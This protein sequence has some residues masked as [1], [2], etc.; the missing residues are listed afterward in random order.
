MAV[1]PGGAVGCNALDAGLALGTTSARNK[2]V[3]LNSY[4]INKYQDLIDANSVVEWF[5]IQVNG[6][7]E[8][9]FTG[10]K[11]G[12]AVTYVHSTK[13][14]AWMLNP[15]IYRTTPIIISQLA[16]QN[17]ERLT[18]LNELKRELSQLKM[19]YE[20]VKHDAVRYQKLIEEQKSVRTP[21]FTKTQWFL[22]C[23]I[24][25]LIG[26]S[27]LPSANAQVT[28][29]RDVIPYLAETQ[30]YL[31]DMLK[32]AFRQAREQIEDIDYTQ[33]I[34]FALHSW[35]VH[36]IATLVFSIVRY[37]NITPTLC[38]ILLSIWSGF[39]V[40][41]GIPLGFSDTLETISY[42]ILLILFP[43]NKFLGLIVYGSAAILVIIS[44]ATNGV[45]AFDPSLVSFFSVVIPL[46]VH[47]VTDNLK[48]PKGYVILFYCAYRIVFFLVKQPEHVLIKNEEGKVVE[49]KPFVPKK[50][51]FARFSQALKNFVQKTVRTGVSPSFQIPAATT[52]KIKTTEGY[53]TAFRLQNYIVTAKHVCASDDIGEVHFEGKKLAVK[54]KWRHPTKDV[55]YFTLPT[56]M[57]CVKP[58]KIGNFTD[59]D[60]LAIVHRDNDYV[61]FAVAKGVVVDDQITYAVQTADGSSGS[62]VINTS[63]KVCGIHVIN[64]GFAAGCV[65]LEQHDLPDSVQPTPK[66]VNMEQNMLVPDVVGL[67]REAIKREMEILR[68]ELAMQELEQ[69]RKGRNKSYRRKGKKKRK[70]WTEQQYRALLDEGFTHDELVKMAEAIRN[71]EDEDIDSGEDEN[72]NPYAYDGFDG[73]IEEVDEDE[74]NEIWFQK[75]GVKTKFK[76]LWY[77]FKAPTPYTHPEHIKDCYMVNVDGGPIHLKSEST[78]RIAKR[79]Q[80]IL[81]FAFNENKWNPNVDKETVLDELQALYYDI[82]YDLYLRDGITLFQAKRQ[83]RKQQQQHQQQQNQNQQQQQQQPSTSKNVKPPQNHQGGKSTTK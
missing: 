60:Y 49:T 41:T 43:L 77:E 1:P 19:E 54:L 50:S 53:G 79:I 3:M 10:I 29:T 16:K 76:Q 26:F 17:Q 37:K 42:A 67:V 61:K 66:E 62:P 63:G 82:N 71:E 8:P 45:F 59:G 55:A 83:Q 4:T 22:L 13:D 48:I 24:G 65:M 74:I 2:G 78:V 69:K 64:T 9:A 15:T 33:I 47:I 32:D 73:L 12:D 39:G 44:N 57:Q 72:Y 46:I 56:E 21:W 18:E 81:E 23:W 27:M 40:L 34:N 58:F 38:T 11:D 7:D 20:V 80:E 51:A 75:D 5:N 14:N 36:V 6:N 70:V 28:G 25:L 35:Q 52:F 31:R 30:D 68:K